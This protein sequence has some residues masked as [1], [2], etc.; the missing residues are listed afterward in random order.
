MQLHELLLI[1]VGLSMDAFAVSIAKGLSM[2]KV[3]AYEAAIV[4]FWFGFFQFLMPLIG[5]FL[6]A[7]FLGQ[8]EAVDHWIAF[9]ILA[10]V[11]GNMIR[12]A[13]TEGKQKTLEASVAE[14]Q[15]KSVSKV[16]PEADLRFHTML[17][18]AI[19]TSIDALAVGI[20][21][22]LLH[23]RIVPAAV[24]IGCVTFVISVCGV[25]VGKAFGTRFQK[26]AA[27]AGGIVLIGIGVKILLEH[28][29]IIA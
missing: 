19:A 18:L 14:E 15:E 1:A 25:Y 26:S 5:A 22:G 17:L 20:T 4:G 16:Q 13:I 23:V 7:K 8:I 6:G 24:F 10:V 9:G 11:G 3:L 28:L 21:F 29:G 12:E 2:R 27:I